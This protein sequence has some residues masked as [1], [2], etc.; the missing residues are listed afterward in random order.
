MNFFGLDSR[1]LKYQRFTPT[2]CKAIKQL[3]V[4]KRVN[5]EGIFK[6]CMDHQTVIDLSLPVFLSYNIVSNMDSI[7]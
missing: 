2:G 1:S 7:G 3:E 6:L 4:K 5:E